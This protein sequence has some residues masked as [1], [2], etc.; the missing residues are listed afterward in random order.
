MAVQWLDGIISVTTHDLNASTVPL[1]TVGAG[2]S[3]IVAMLLTPRE[4]LC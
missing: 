1:A 4:Y 2:M 3:Y